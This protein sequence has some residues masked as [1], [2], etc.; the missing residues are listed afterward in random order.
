MFICTI[1]DMGNLARLKQAGADAILIGIQDLSVAAIQAIPF[2]KLADWKQACQQEGLRLYVNACRLVMDDQWPLVVDLV[3][4]AK[5]LD[6][7]IYF[8]DEGLLY[9]AQKLGLTKLVYQPETLVTHGAD[10]CFFLNQQVEAVS[11]AHELSLEEIQQIAQVGRCEVLVS[12]YV[13][14]LYSRRRL[15]TNYLNEIGYT[16]PVDKRQTYVIE[17]N[18]SGKMPIIEEESGTHIFSEAP[19]ESSKV[20][21]QLGVDRYR[22][23]SLFMDDEWTFSVLSAYQHHEPLEGLSHFYE[24]ESLVRK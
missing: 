17:A 10:V 16:Q 13:P 3:N 7:G 22:I 15:I 23:D 18:R 4:R 2:D 20:F 5:Q 8:S 14:I 9:E 11:L 19:I 6:I 21:D 24:Q 1:H 12:G